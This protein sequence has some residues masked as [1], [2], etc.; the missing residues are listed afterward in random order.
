MNER[1]CYQQAVRAETGLDDDTTIGA[2]GIQ[3]R[4]ATATEPASRLAFS[5]TP[6]MSAIAR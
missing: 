3:S 1:T 2:L 6:S 4:S 5:S